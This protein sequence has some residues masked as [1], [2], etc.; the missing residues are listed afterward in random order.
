[1]ISV[2]KATRQ[3]LWAALTSKGVE[4]EMTWK[5]SSREDMMAACIKADITEVT[6]ISETS[7]LMKKLAKTFTPEFFATMR[8][9]EAGIKAAQESDLVTSEDSEDEA[10][11]ATADMGAEPANVNR[12]LVAALKKN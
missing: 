4:G 11:T 7:A 6:P 10:A 3:E 8:D 12:Q 9:L 2:F 1:M 5:T